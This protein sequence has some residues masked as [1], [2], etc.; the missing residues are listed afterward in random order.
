[1]NVDSQLLPPG[2]RAA[3]AEEIVFGTGSDTAMDDK[4]AA[5]CYNH[6]KFCASIFALHPKA[7]SV[8]WCNLFTWTQSSNVFRYVIT[9]GFLKSVNLE[10]R[11][12]EFQTARTVSVD[13]MDEEACRL[14]EFLRRRS[15]AS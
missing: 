2:L 5:A 8:K 11:P 13:A 3:A 1:L 4:K 15:L 14:Y 7:S 9:G 12:E 6:A 10:Q